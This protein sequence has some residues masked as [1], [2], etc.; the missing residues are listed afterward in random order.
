MFTPKKKGFKVKD[1]L[2]PPK[3]VPK[4]K[5]MVK[6]PKHLETYELD[7]IVVPSKK[8]DEIKGEV[9]IST[10]DLDSSE[11]SLSPIADGPRSYVMKQ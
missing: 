8:A 5:R 3:S 4:P 1:L 9:V 7:P 2:T 11:S 6:R 10:F